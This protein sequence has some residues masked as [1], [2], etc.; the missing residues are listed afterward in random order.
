MN[1]PASKHLPL[2]KKGTLDYAEWLADKLRNSGDYNKEAAELLVHQAKTL[3]YLTASRDGRVSPALV[4]LLT[5]IMFQGYNIINDEQ[6]LG[7]RLP[8]EEERVEI[9][10]IVRDAAKRNAE[11]I[12]ELLSKESEQ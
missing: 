12:I 3:E 1:E 2:L 8:T 10:R 9:A 11:H 7:N 5:N 6:P 4:E